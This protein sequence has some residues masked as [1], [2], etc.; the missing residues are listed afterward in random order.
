MALAVG[1]TWAAA[2]IGVLQSSAV[3]YR[4]EEEERAWDL[5]TPL[6]IAGVGLLAT[7]WALT[8]R[9]GDLTGLSL[10]AAT[11]VGLLALWQE[12]TWGRVMS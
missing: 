1:L 10:T 9:R 8:R 12:S 4:W 5:A 2:G 6:L 3:L 11:A 7:A